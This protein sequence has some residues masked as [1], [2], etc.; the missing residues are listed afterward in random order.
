MG[1]HYT[2]ALNYAIKMPDG[3]IRY[4]G[5]TENKSTEGWNYL[6]SKTKI[7][8]GIENDFIVFKKTQGKWNVYNKR[9]SK[10]DNT[11]KPFNRTTPFRNLITSDQCNTAQGTAEITSV[12]SIRKFDF[13]KPSK[14]IKHLLLNIV[15]SHC[16]SITDSSS[17]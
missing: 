1:G 7:Q 8:W 4:P 12:L 16:S 9:Y 10:I 13:P 17:F 15:R 11:G 6:W 5:G 14:L 2:D 3:T